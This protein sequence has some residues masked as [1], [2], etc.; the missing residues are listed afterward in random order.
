MQTQTTAV[1]ASLMA[2]TAV[3]AMPTDASPD[4]HVGLTNGVNRLLGGSALAGSVITCVV[5]I[6]VTM[7]EEQPVTTV[8]VFGILSG[9]IDSSTPNPPASFPDQ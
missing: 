4:E 8:R 1:P 9:H 7:A 5:L 3:I 2:L 6:A